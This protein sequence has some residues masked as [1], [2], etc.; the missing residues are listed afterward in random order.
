MSVTGGN[1]VGLVRL[2]EVLSF[3]LLDESV[4]DRGHSTQCQGVTVRIEADT[5]PPIRFRE[6]ICDDYSCEHGGAAG[7]RGL[8]HRLPLDGLRDGIRSNGSQSRHFHR[9]QTAIER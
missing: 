3:L 5:L 4:R 1:Q 2:G 6:D 8:P 9:Q 7:T